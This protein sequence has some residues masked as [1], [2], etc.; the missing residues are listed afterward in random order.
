MRPLIEACLFQFSSKSK[1]DAEHIGS[2][3]KSTIRS[4]SSDPA[5]KKMCIQ[6]RDLYDAT[7]KYHHGADGGSLLGISWINPNEVE[8]FDEVIMSVVKMIQDNK[9]VRP[10]VA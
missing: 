3:I 8:Y 6:L 2:M 1:F 10:I 5:R 9:M 7:K 4:N